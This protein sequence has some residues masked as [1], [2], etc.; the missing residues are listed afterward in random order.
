MPGLPIVGLLSFLL[1][2]CACGGGSGGG[3]SSPSGSLTLQAVWERPSTGGGAQFEGGTEIPPS[4]QTVEVRIVGGG[5]TFR[6]LVDPEETRSVVI[7]EV[8]TGDVDVTVFGYD[9]PLLGVPDLQD[10]AVAPSYA[11]APVQVLVRAGV[12]T[13]AGQI[14]VLAQPFLTDFA[15][16]PDETDVDPSRDVEFLLAIGVGAIDAGS[17]DVSVGGTP[18]VSAGVPA[19]NVT[20]EPCADGTATPCGTIDRQVTGFLF[21]TAPGGLPAQSTVQVSVNATGGPGSS[22]SLDFSYELETSGS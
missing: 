1:L 7:T 17:V 14:E 4:V 12:T 22:R 15:P 16:V 9:V 8:P 20:F 3:G 13:N 18:L 2:C 11:S 21:R 6:Q 5:Q 10:V 19:A